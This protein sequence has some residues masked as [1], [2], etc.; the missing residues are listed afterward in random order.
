MK[1]EILEQALTDIRT[2]YLEEAME[3]MKNKNGTGRKKR[4]LLVP[5]AVIAFVL[6]IS[7]TAAA[8]SPVDLKTYL[9]AAFNGGYEL[10]DEMVSMP[11]YV[12]YRSSGDEI[13]LTMRGILGDSQTALVFFDLTAAP[14]VD[15]PEVYADYDGGIDIAWY[16]MPSFRGG[17]G[18]GAMQVLE[19]TENA[20]G[21]VTQKMSIDITSENLPLGKPVVLTLRGIS[22]YDPSTYEKTERIRG[23]WQMTFPL[24]YK[25]STVIYPF[26]TEIMADMAFDSY[27][28][29]PTEVVSLHVS[30]VRLSPLS[31]MICADTDMD[32]D[33]DIG[34]M[35]P[36]LNL[37]R[38][39][40]TLI[41]DGEN[42]VCRMYGASKPNPETGRRMNQW[43]YQFT[44]QIPVDEIAA[45]CLGDAEL[46]L[47]AAEAE[48]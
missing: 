38:A 14:G 36:V 26:D 1:K 22:E 34:G 29:A 48:S 16:L 11:K 46:P 4:L 31:V 27:P 20:D 8:W 35:T 25:D 23:K 7:L 9:G 32:I 5:A 44:S 3:T 37:R 6:C 33:E 39:D 18:S 24:D 17:F 47:A 10:L 41:L 28:D 12:S 42:R 30:E 40:G 19:R 43:I 45:V 13:K 15:I 21:S 2:E